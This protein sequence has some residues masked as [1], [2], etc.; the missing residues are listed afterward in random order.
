MKLI[1]VAPIGQHSSLAFVMRESGCGIEDVVAVDFP[2]EHEE[3][4]RKLRNTRVIAGIGLRQCA[5]LFGISVVELCKLERGSSTL[6][7]ADWD[8]VYKIIE[9][10]KEKS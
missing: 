1:P 6:S 5:K 7:E 10:H 2:P 4:G 9:E 8:W 3:R